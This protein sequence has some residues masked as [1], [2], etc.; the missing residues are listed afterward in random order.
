[1]D[2]NKRLK[3]LFKKVSDQQKKDQRD[4]A[5]RVTRYVNRSK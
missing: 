2:T 3:D 1:M 5:E 4:F